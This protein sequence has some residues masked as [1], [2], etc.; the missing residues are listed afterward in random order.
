MATGIRLA[1]P[2]FHY[3]D[4]SGNPLESGTLTFYLA[5]S[6]TLTNVY[7]DSAL[8]TSAGSTVTLDTYGNTRV[9]VNPNINYKIIVKD[10]AGNTVDTLD[11][12]VGLYNP[13]TYATTA[14]TPN[15]ISD[16]LI[17]EYVSSTSFKIKAGNTIDSSN[18]YRIANASDFTCV[19]SS[20]WQAGS[21]LGCFPSSLTLSAGVWYHA[22]VLYNPTSGAV[23]AGVDS[24]I[25]A[26]NLL[27]DSTASGYTKYRRVGS[28]YYNGSTAIQPFDQMGD[29]TYFRNPIETVAITTDPGTSVMNKTMY[30]PTGINSMRALVR[31]LIAETAGS[32]SSMYMG[33]PNATLTSANR[34]AIADASSSVSEFICPVNSNGVLKVQFSASTV[35]VSYSLHTAG[36]FELRGKEL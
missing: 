27:A 22:F 1:T 36:Y 29:Y 34:I 24:N 8:N 31:V 21:G 26:T 9:F 17:L 6:T 7:L 16:D 2:L 28:I 32:A 12:S 5:G 25:L 18:T 20:D 23:S 4:V 11:E 14:V 33:H 3:D 13:V 35:N 19:I 10:K 30:V 15:F